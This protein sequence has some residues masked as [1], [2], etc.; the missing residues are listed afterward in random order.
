M[1]QKPKKPIKLVKR[2]NDVLVS[3]IRLMTKRDW[4]VVSAVRTEDLVD[5]LFQKGQETVVLTI[6][7]YVE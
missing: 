5:G 7:R 2:K 6:T 3:L 4:Q 1:T